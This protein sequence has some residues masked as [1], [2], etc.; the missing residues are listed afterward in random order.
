MAT[1]LATE[2]KVHH[3]LRTLSFTGAPGPNGEQPVEQVDA[4]LSEYLQNGYHLLAT[5][6]AGETPGGIR[7][8]YVLVQNGLA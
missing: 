7:L 3:M 2:T 8:L 1:K 5:H 4:D 6:Y